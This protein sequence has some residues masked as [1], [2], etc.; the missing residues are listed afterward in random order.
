MA[1]ADRYF[2][3]GG[4]R[5]RYR[6][7]GA[8][9]AILWLHGWTQDLELWDPQCAE[10]RA[11]SRVLRFDRRGFGRSGGQPDL[12]ADV[13]DLRALLDQLE[14]ERTV[15]V[16]A[17]QGARVA[18]AFALGHR[19]RVMS[20]VLDGP[21]NPAE[22]AQAAEEISLDA[23]RALMR[24]G[25]IA[26]FREAW[27]RHPL[28]RLRTSDPGARKLLDTM[29]ERYRGLDL[30]PADSSLPGLDAP[31][32]A[33]LGLPVLIVNGQYDTP[34]RRRAGLELCRSI[35]GA[36]HAVIADAGHLANLD[37]PRAYNE[38]IRS[39]LRRQSLAAA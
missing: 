34:A 29:L 20:L 33:R 38:A 19:E 12:V 18:L 28:M 6:D 26:A 1:S 27:R 37:E 25:G 35:P 14:I 10:F 7:Q 13:S 31:A 17:S 5:L 23:H 3:T 22:D 11:T 15:L 2:M 8:G 21:P 16:G 9:G 4:L 24:D 30:L 36:E 32:L 39:F